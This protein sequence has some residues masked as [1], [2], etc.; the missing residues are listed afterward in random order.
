M[1]S[2]VTTISRGA[3]WR[4]HMR[5][6]CLN[7]Y[8]YVT[9][10][11]APHCQL[12]IFPKTLAPWVEHKMAFGEY[13]N[14][15]PLIMLKICRGI[16][17]VLWHPGV[18]ISVRVTS[19]WCFSKAGSTLFSNA[20]RCDFKFQPHIVHACI[21]AHTNIYSGIKTGA[22]LERFWRIKTRVEGLVKACL[23]F[24]GAQQQ[25]NQLLGSDF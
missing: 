2:A 11:F 1:F 22:P 16:F 25:L 18:P 15:L 5:S 19:R 10:H 13:R 9:P 23:S 21:Y 8:K 17:L 7:P 24:R 3:V 14:F 20:Q 4:P 6:V 12:V